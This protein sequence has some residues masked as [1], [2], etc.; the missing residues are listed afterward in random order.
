MFFND[1]NGQTS[2]L[3]PFSKHP[4]TEKGLKFQSVYHYYTFNKF[5]KFKPIDPQR[6]AASLNSKTTKILIQI[7]NSRRHRIIP[8]WDSKKYGIMKRGYELKFQQHKDIKQGLI[9]LQAPELKYTAQPMFKYWGCYGENMLGKL[10][11]ELKKK[12]IEESISKPKPVPVKKMVTPP[13]PVSTNARVVKINNVRQFADVLYQVPVPV[14]PPS[15][16]GHGFLKPLSVS[17]DEVDGIIAVPVPSMEMLLPKNNTKQ[18]VSEKF[19]TSTDNIKQE[20]IDRGDLSKIITHEYEKLKIKQTSFVK[21]EPKQ[22]EL[23]VT[24]VVKKVK[25]NQCLNKLTSSHVVEKPKHDTH[26]KEL[27]VLSFDSL[28]NNVENA[29]YIPLSEKKLI[30]GEDVD[31]DILISISKKLNELDMTKKIC[32]TDATGWYSSVLQNL[33]KAIAGKSVDM[34]S[35]EGKY[36][37]GIMDRHPELAM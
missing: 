28:D 35:P 33:S 22:E 13:V 16:A 21:Q 36:A 5:N 15:L 19:F 37:Q 30:T 3:S 2:Y 27:L 14:L 17:D 20:E 12:Y 1:G 10:L 18:S 31:D 32:L 25:D 11:L 24:P 23:K 26:Q 6:A 8:D 34:K 29:I 7:G 9:D 4:I